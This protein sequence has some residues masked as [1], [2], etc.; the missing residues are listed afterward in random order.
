M[1]DEG[2]NIEEE[3]EELSLLDDVFETEENLHLEAT[4]ENLNA[5]TS[6]SSDLDEEDKRRLFK[7]LTVILTRRWVKEDRVMI[8]CS[9]NDL[10]IATSLTIDALEPVL[11]EYSKIVGILGLEL[12]D[13]KKDEQ[14][15]FCLRSAY[16]APTELKTDV[17]MVLGLIIALIERDTK[18]HIETKQLKKLLLSNNIMKEYAIDQCLKELHQQGYI[19]RKMRGNILQYDYRTIIEFGLDERKKIVEEF[20][21]I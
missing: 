9:L 1:M 20:R 11:T 10:L 17:M 7:E 15:W 21:N 6:F 18:Q 2:R 14:K 5:F 13:Y 19:L 8:G 4:F 16:Y 12:V 3:D